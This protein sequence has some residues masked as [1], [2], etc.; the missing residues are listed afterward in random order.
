MPRSNV[1][2]VTD[3]LRR[4]LE[5][6]PA[7][8]PRS[9]LEP[10]RGFILR[11]RREGRTYRN[12]QQILADE[13]HVSV[14]HRTIIQFVKRRSRPRKPQ[15]ELEPEV[16]AMAPTAKLPAAVPGRKLTP[17]ERA[18]QVEYIRSL[19]KPE[20]VVEKPKPLF[21]PDLSKPRTNIKQ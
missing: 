13:C 14:T 4:T 19:N 3:D 18:A 8:N 17:E 12:I 6:L 7:A 9:R 5:N 2:V 20:V 10:F 16:P 15:P 1:F 11:W 21:D